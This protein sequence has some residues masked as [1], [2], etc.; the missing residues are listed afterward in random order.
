MRPGTPPQRSAM[1]SLRFLPLAET[2]SLAV[3]WSFP[4]S[5][6]G[7]TAVECTVF[8]TLKSLYAAH[9]AAGLRPGGQN[10]CQSAKVI[11]TGA[12]QEIPLP[13]RIAGPHDPADN[14]GKET[15]PS[16][17]DTFA[18][19]LIICLDALRALAI[20]AKFLESAWPTVWLSLKRASAIFGASLT[21]CSGCSP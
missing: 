8:P 2:L 18:L 12:A 6:F 7:R 4:R 11:R 14:S 13:L 5:G 10:C 15:E 16:L 20:R 21:F 19:C 1:D 17:C 3:R 9:G